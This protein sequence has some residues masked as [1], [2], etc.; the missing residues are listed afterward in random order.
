MTKVNNNQPEDIKILQT[1]EKENVMQAET[2]NRKE[3]FIKKI[4]QP[5]IRPRYSYEHSGTGY[6]GL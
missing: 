5:Y 4:D 1:N 6:Q 2:A 3:A